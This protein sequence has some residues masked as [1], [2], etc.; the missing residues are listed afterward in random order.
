MLKSVLSG[1]ELVSEDAGI[2]RAHL[3]WS[4]GQLAKFSRDPLSPCLFG[5]RLFHR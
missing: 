2:V 1:T 4:Q 5:E 3:D